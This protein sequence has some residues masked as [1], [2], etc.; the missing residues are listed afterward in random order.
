MRRLILIITGNLIMFSS[1]P[2]RAVSQNITQ[3]V[4]AAQSS[5]TAVPA[6]WLGKYSTYFSY[7][8]I[9]GQNAGW[10]LEI[11]ITNNKI[12]A[13]GEGFQMAFEDELSAKVN[14]SRLL[15]SHVKNLSGYTRG[16]AMKPEF[17]LIKDHGKF[18]IQS[19]WIDD[20][21]VNTKRASLG[22]IIERVK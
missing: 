22:Y 10:A 15:L 12:T 19:Q 11:N 20:G 13:K 8:D 14:G 9:A 7:G 3:K 5:H 18:Y 16:K 17:T 6:T 1:F 21:D 2:Q 4:V